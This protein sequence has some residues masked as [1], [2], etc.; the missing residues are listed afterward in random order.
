MTYYDDS[1]GDLIYATYDGVSWHRTIADW[2]NDTGLW[3]SLALDASDRPHVGYYDLL[4]TAL[5]Y[6]YLCVGVEAVDI[7]GPRALPAGEAGFYSATFFPV[8]ATTPITSQWDNGTMGPTAVYSWTL[9]GLYTVTVTATNACQVTVTSI[10]VTVCPSEA[11]R[12]VRQTVD[13]AG[14]V[15]EYAS[16]ALD[17]AGYA[18]VSYLDHSNYRLKYAQNLAGTWQSEVVD[19]NTEAGWY[20][21]LALDAAGNAHISYYA[22]WP[23]LD[24]KYAYWDGAAWQTEVVD[25]AGDV[26]WYTSLALDA[27]GYPHISYYDR[28]TRD[29]KYVW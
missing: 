5:K 20:S 28:T 9:P 19:P 8:T 15:G 17:A 12:W 13:S 2:D 6:A 22:S 29:L 11:H 21:A 26:G 23:G 16:L 27:A 24:L 1:W 25:S 14:N 7:A 10:T 18:H 3:T 4:R